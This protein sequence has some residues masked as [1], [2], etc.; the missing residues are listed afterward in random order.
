[1]NAPLK[2]NHGG[3]PV[4]WSDRA[5]GTPRI[6]VFAQG[7]T[8]ADL[9]RQAIGRHGLPAHFAD[10]GAVAING[11]PVPREWWLYVRPKSVAGRDIV[12]TFYWP[13]AGGGGQGGKNPLATVAMIGVLVAALAAGPFVGQFAWFALGGLGVAP[14]LVGSLAS[15]AIGVGGSLAVAALTGPPKQEDPAAAPGMPVSEQAAALAGN[16]LNPGGA[17][18]RVIGTHIVYPPFAQEP[19]AEIIEA[20]RVRIEALY[21]LTGGHDIDDVRFGGIGADSMENVEVETFE[22]QT[23][24]AAVTLADVHAAI[25]LVERQGK[26]HPIAVEVSHHQIDGADGDYSI[27]QDQDDPEGDLPVWHA[28]VTGVD[29]DQFWINLEWPGGINWA[30]GAGFAFAVPIRVRMRRRGDE[31]WIYIPEIH[32]NATSTNALRRSI[33]LIWDEPPDV[34]PTPQ[35]AR[36]VHAAWKHVPGQDTTPATDAFDADAH[37][38]AGA[39]DDLLDAATYLTSKV[40]NVELYPHYAGIYLHGE[41]F[42]SDGDRWEVQFKV[43]CAYPKVSLNSSYVMAASDV[44]PN[45]ATFD[46]F[47]YFSVGGIHCTPVKITAVTAMCRVDRCFSIWHEHPI[48]SADFAAIAVRTIGQQ[49]G[50]L[51]AVA[52]G[53]VQ[54]WDGSAWATWET[55]S[56]PA[57][58]Y[59]EVMAGRLNADPLPADLV[60]DDVLV[61]WRQECIDNDYTCDAVVN[62]RSGDDVLNMLAFCGYARPR[63]S[64]TWD[65]LIDRDRSG[66]APTQIF[67]FRNMRSFRF[68]RT[69]ANRPTGFRVKFDDVADDYKETTV[70][71]LDPLDPDADTSRLEEIGYEGFV[72]EDKTVARAEFDLKQSDLRFVFYFGECGIESIV[73]RRG[74]LVGVQHDV[75]SRPVGSARIKSVTTSGGNVTGLVLDGSIP[76]E[77]SE[78]FYLS[79]GDDD[80]YTESGGEDFYLDGDVGV[81]IR[82]LDQTLLTK[83]IVA[84]GGEAKTVTFSTPFAIPGGGVLAA[85]CLLVSG[86]LASEYSRMIVFDI[87]PKNDLEATLTFVPEAPELFQ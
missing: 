75:L 13:L 58:H 14:A 85:D 16:V 80:F 5:L 57:P 42:E 30:E 65:V 84:S 67:S 52:A 37:F 24:A 18:P 68:E 34:L 8:I 73:C 4:V 83:Q 28:V 74:D 55:T 86:D 51:S 3:V 82:L 17:V 59:R 66:D 87:A 35:S 2:R 11:E 62:G 23:S 20:D 43:G 50:Q 1:M 25:T 32:V 41:T 76:L 27:L 19:I 9:V 15:A 31:D 21:V 78:A 79:D 60:G 39:G 22:G 45:P 47:H 54:D 10:R 29:P 81:A 70:T 49:L 6:A 36:G 69:F 63:Q 40:E 71:V 48:Q 26:A 12:V 7:A 44:V 72:D 77:A 33:R 53:Y 46:L 61:E 38:S 64:E 56:N